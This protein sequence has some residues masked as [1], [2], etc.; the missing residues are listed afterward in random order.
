M[1]AIAGFWHLGGRPDAGSQCAAMLA[2]QAVYGPHDGAQWQDSTIALGR[3]LFRTVS[4][5]RYDHGPLSLAGGNQMLVADIRL[6]N[7][8]E[9]LNL[10]QI[11]AAPAAELCDTAILAQ[12]VERWGENC[13]DHLVGDFAF[14]LWDSREQ[15]LLLARDCLG[16][17]PL[18]FHRGRDFFAFA[19]MPVGLHALAEIPRAPDE[20]RM[21]DFLSA[22]PEAGPQSFFQGIDRVEAGHIVVLSRQGVHTRRYWNPPTQTLRL[23]GPEEYAEALRFQLD[24]AT[25]AR[26]RGCNGVVGAHLS[27]GFDSSAVCATAAR[28]LAPTG[29]RVLAYTSVPRAGY[30]LPD[31]PRHLLDEGPLAAQVAARYTN[32][33]HHLIHGRQASP[34]TALPQLTALTNRPI[35]NPCNLSWGEDIHAE[36]RQRNVGVLLGGGMGNLSLSL[37]GRLWL[38]ELIADGRWLRWYSEARALVNQ[39]RLRW[40]GALATSLAPWLPHGLLDLLRRRLGRVP[41][42]ATLAAIHPAHMA[43]FSRH[44][45][46]AL[47]RVHE[48]RLT[49]LHR[50]DAGN[51][52]KGTLA[53]WGIDCRD[54]TADRRL[55]EFSLAVPMEQFLSQGTTRA[56]ARRALADRLPAELLNERRKGLQAIDWHEGLDAAR[57]QLSAELQRIADSAVAARV[58]DIPRLQQLLAQWPAGDWHRPDISLAYRSTLLRAIACG[59]FLRTA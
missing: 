12:A 44:P 10:L 19:S 4:E 21:L 25:Q 53:A 33:E 6:D 56:L 30:P 34:L 37:D 18:H 2:A 1:T 32:I 41:D 3:Q 28:L 5:D 49:T 22:R 47:K 43:E 58:L 57:D 17:R 29:G 54:P 39:R 36:L 27:A 14:A 42:I 11:P 35:L 13:V 20:R 7:R 52:L 59:H 8:T 15:R 48:T 26:L 9:L 40:R 16:Q 23:S 31:F 38:T 50:I 55:V 46:V 51:Y 45:F 24:Q